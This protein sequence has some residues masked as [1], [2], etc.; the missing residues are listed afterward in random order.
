MPKRKYPSLQKRHI[1][2]VGAEEQLMYERILQSAK[3]DGRYKG[4]EEEVAARTV[5]RFHRLAGHR[6]GQ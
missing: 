1:P 2:G 6:P 4:R 3:R 5:L